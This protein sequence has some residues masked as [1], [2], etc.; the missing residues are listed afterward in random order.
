MTAPLQFTT[1]MRR[2]RRERTDAAALGIAGFVVA[3]DAHDYPMALDAFDRALALSNSNFFALS[4]SALA[5]SWMGT[6]EVAIERAHRAL[7][8]SPSIR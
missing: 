1:L 7:R 5:L 4:S 6:V 2:L 3:L 8:L